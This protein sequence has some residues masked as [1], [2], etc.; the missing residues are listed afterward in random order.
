MKRPCVSSSM[1]SRFLFDSQ[2][3]FY[4]DVF[5]YNFCG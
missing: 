1:N 2:K 4:F 5:I 3:K